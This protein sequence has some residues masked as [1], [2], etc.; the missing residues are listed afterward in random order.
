M[1][2][3]IKDKSTD[4]IEQVWKLLD[5]ADAVVHYNG[6]K[7]DIPVLHKEFLLRGLGPPS[8]F[9][10][11]DLLKTVRKQFKFESNKLDYVCQRLGLG[12][13]TQHKGM[14]L[15]Y[16]CMEGNK[17]SWRIMERYNKQDVR[18]LRKLYR[19]LLPWIH[20]HPNVGMWVDDPKKPTCSN[21]GSTNVV[22]KGTQYNSKAAS[23][24]RW[25][26]N[27]CGTPLRSRLRSKPTSENV[28]M[29]TN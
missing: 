29:R 8:H 28:L 1:Y 3:S 7:F 9:H 4:F 12:A 27:S 25:S 11:I 14:S 2:G 10:Q 19:K 22:S 20:N 15:W 5:D 13:K 24:Q 16:G 17:A 18:L 23:Y 6:S 21:C 26:C